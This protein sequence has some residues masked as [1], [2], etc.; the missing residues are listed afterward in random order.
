MVLP[1]ADL[2]APGSPPIRPERS[3]T[4]MDM[5]NPRTSGPMLM[6]PQK[7]AGPSNSSSGP[8]SAGR[9]NGSSRA[10]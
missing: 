5:A 6:R 10:T 7:F 3:T 8:R 2:P 4:L 1:D 9:V